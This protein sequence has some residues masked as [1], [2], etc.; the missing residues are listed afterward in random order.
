MLKKIF[1]EK[2]IILTLTDLII[3]LFISCIS[4]ITPNYFYTFIMNTTY[5]YSPVKLTLG[6]KYL[7]VISILL[8]G[9]LYF[10]NILAIYKNRFSYF[11]RAEILISLLFSLIIGYQL[12][13]ISY[14]F[15]KYFTNAC[16]FYSFF[17]LI[18]IFTW[19]NYA[20]KI[21]N[22]FTKAM[23]QISYQ[24]KKLSYLIIIFILLQFLSLY[25]TIGN[26][27]KMAKGTAILAY[28]LLWISVIVELVEGKKSV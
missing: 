2:L 25:F 5:E 4:I 24:N 7:T 9:L 12:S 21:I 15:R 1:N 13:G 10:W 18:L 19:R 28:F 16:M 22:V 20:S 23:D 8:I 14:D 3:L 27:T 6:L 26:L 11:N 17:Y